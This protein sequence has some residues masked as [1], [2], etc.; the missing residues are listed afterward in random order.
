MATIKEQK[1]QDKQREAAIF[2]AAYKKV[3]DYKYAIIALPGRKNYGT[4]QNPDYETLYNPYLQASAVVLMAQ[5][6]HQSKDAV[7]DSK[8]EWMEIANH[9]ICEV[10]IISTIYGQ[11]KGSKRVDLNE[12]NLDKAFEEAQTGAMA[13]ALNFAGGYGLFAGDGLSDELSDEGRATSEDKPNN[14]RPLAS[15]ELIEDIGKSLWGAGV[16]EADVKPFL[17]IMMARMPK[18]KLYQDQAEG[19][20]S[21]VNGASV[22]P[23]SFFD[24]YLRFLCKKHKKEQQIVRDFIDSAYDGIELSSLEAHQQQELIAFIKET[25]NANEC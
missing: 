10:T 17:T 22:I 8:T 24:P 23:V 20:F 2:N 4:R 5:E 7:F 16:A 6:D 14:E 12:N 21:T 19:W 25:D 3:G 1:V 13:R 18:G 9:V 15:P 11:H